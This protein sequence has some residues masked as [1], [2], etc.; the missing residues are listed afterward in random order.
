[1]LPPML[2]LTMAE[3]GTGIFAIIA[4]RSKPGEL[5]GMWLAI[6]G[7]ALSAV[8]VLGAIVFEFMSFF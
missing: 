6:V 2:M 5:T 7:I 4:I 3:I 1:V 8:A